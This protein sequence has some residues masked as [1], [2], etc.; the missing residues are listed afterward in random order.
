[1]LIINPLSI[2]LNITIKRNS[3]VNSNN[4]NYGVYCIVVY[5][6]YKH[7]MKMTYLTNQS[8]KVIFLLIRMVLLKLVI[9]PFLIREPIM[10]ESLISYKNKDKEN[11][12]NYNPNRS[13]TTKHNKAIPILNK[14]IKI[15][16]INLLKWKILLS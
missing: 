9:L 16:S 3:P 13:M 15:L 5:Q 1:M 6:A 2:I 10:I 7:Y 11:K 8:Q 14:L 12:E 4:I